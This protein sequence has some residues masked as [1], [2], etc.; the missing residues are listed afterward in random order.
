[1][2]GRVVAP[3]ELTRSDLAGWSD[4]AAHVLEPNPF[5]EPNWLLPALTYLDESPQTKLV[6]AESGG[7]VQACVPIMEITADESDHAGHGEHLALK[8]RVA[9]TAISLGTPLLSVEGGREAL[10][11][12]MTEIKREA[13]LRQ[14]NLVVMEWMGYDGPTARLL[15]E[16]AVEA[17]TLIIEFDTWERGFLRRQATDEE[18]YWLRNIGKNRRRTIGQHRRQL[19][20]A[21][22]T[23]PSLRKRTDGSAVDDFLR[24]ESS[25]WKGHQPDGLAL[26]R[27]AATTRF[28]EAVCD[29]YIGE[30]RMWFLSLEGDGAPV[31]MICCVT[32]GEG[33]FAYRTAYD[34]DLARYGPGVE[35]FLAAMEY[36]DRETDALWFDTC[37]TRDN[38]HLLGL[39]PDRRRMA[40]MM[41]RVP[42]AT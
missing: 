3:S 4:C 10:T 20:T 19:S 28:F 2:R 24:L 42:G 33:I 14:A 18:C 29:R 9:P 12:L 25:G 17:N 1:M 15:K 13:E 6:L 21:L 5:L 26:W 22:G 38:T 35:I 34:E 36:F 37:S 32:A 8:T 11:C 40:T 31:A 23:S 16:A 30:G 41:F 7:S 39:F 27:Q